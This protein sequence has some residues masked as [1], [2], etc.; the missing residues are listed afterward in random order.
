MRR[1]EESH[2]GRVESDPAT[3]TGR[4]W[5]VAL[6][7]GLGRGLRG[8]LPLA[9]FLAAAPNGTAWGEGVSFGREVLPIL[10]DACFACHGPDEGGRK[11]KLR[12][13]IPEGAARVLEPGNPGGSELL[14]RM[15]ATDPKDRMPPAD[16][17]LKV[18]PG[19]VEVIR[20]WI[21]GGAVWG[22]HWAFEP[23]TRPSPP[24]P[25]PHASLERN[26]L[27]RFVLAKLAD[28]GL[29]PAREAGRETLIRRATLGLTGLPPDPE[30]VAAYLE[31]DSPDA[32]ERLVDRLLDS[33]AY[34]ERMAW[35]WLDAARYADSN[36]YQGD[37]DRT[38]WPWRDW[39]VEAFNRNLSYDQFTIWQL[40]GDLLP[41]ATIE[42]RLATGFA[43]NH[44]IN[45]EGGRIAEENR[46]EYVMDMAE[47]AGTVWLGLTFNCC[48]CHDHKYDPLTQRDYFGMFAFFNQTPVDGGGGNPQTPPVLEMPTERQLGR[49]DEL[50]AA[51][52]GAAKSVLEKEKSLKDLLNISPGDRSAGQL[53]ALQKF[54]GKP[55]GELA[56]EVANLKQLR[57][58][59]DQLNRAIPKVMV[60]ADMEKPRTTR[61]LDRGQYDKPGVEVEA[62]VPASLPPLPSGAPL[63]RLGLAQWIVDPANPLTA[64]VTVNR[65]WQQF[66][67]VGLVKTSEDFGVQAEIPS[68]PEL[69]DWLA[70]EFIESGWDVKRLVRLMVTSAAFRR[71][72]RSTPGMLERDPD[73]RFL[74]RGPR[75]RIPFWM[76]RDQAL[77]AAELLVRQVG[78][79]P[80]HPYQPEGVWEDATFG[81]RSYPQSKGE[82]LYRRSIYAFWRRII[83]PPMFF[84]NPSRQVCTVRQPRT[85]TPLQALALM[86]DPTHVEAA[87]SLAS[88]A[89]LRG[90]DSLETRLDFMAAKVLARGLQS[91][92]RA[93]LASAHERLLRQ[94]GERPEEAAKLTGV[95]DSKPDPRL[96]PV[97][98][99]A[100]AGVATILLNLD[101]TVTHE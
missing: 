90:G 88:A 70:A 52:S 64:R 21:E 62:S 37:S 86:N 55:D 58:Q 84:D 94:Y 19:Q 69:L 44:M 26:E 29:E 17:H 45:G 38:M 16:S 12:L 100:M 50:A 95:G 4:R 15:E 39:V 78:G 10:S 54:L 28:V 22:K 47:T 31:D 27:D 65:F 2:V 40:A 8:L 74:A 71:D 75:H 96:D 32:Y 42:Q 5:V 85:N 93:V 83:A 6:A 79:A 25:G 49:R 91:R 33:P 66:F 36:G 34:G 81:A 68:N 73:N 14:R 30:A 48:R 3:W 77:A 13:D 43:R 51:I 101:E 82:G 61:M 92:E 67:G 1:E 18:T 80:T 9:V 57:D 63:N 59:M 7:S 23:L 35:D 98:L 72:S 41:D 11:A 76:I 24:E 53:D 46:V 89:M 99:A 87:R 56:K 20:R 97:R 60:M